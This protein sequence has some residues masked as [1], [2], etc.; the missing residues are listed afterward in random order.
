M[1][2]IVILV[3][4]LLYV[5]AHRGQ[6]YRHKINSDNFRELAKEFDDGDGDSPD[7]VEQEEFGDFNPEGDSLNDFPAENEAFAGDDFEGEGSPIEDDTPLSDDGDG[8]D[9]TAT[10]QTPVGEEDEQ[11]QGGPPPPEDSEGKMITISGFPEHVPGTEV[12]RGALNG[13]YYE[14]TCEIQGHPTYWQEKSDDLKEGETPFLYWCGTNS[15]NNNRVHKKWSII[16]AREY[17]KVK[18]GACITY[19][20]FPPKEEELKEGLQPTSVYKGWHDGKDLGFTTQDE[21]KEDD[22]ADVKIEK[23]EK[24]DRP[25]VNCEELL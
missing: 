20:P 22:W 11:I 4:A 15:T 9:A 7:N 8:E 24:M 10:P 14:S 21:M 18:D 23:I 6:S 19:A 2:R 16:N 17:G 13:V 3:S 1:V 25:K 5:V 12:L